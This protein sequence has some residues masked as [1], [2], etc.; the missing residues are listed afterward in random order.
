MWARRRNQSSAS[1]IH[2]VVLDRENRTPLCQSVA[3]QL[4]Q[5]SQQCGPFF[6]RDESAIDYGAVR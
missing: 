3:L 2:C 5:I 1:R 4:A 6:R